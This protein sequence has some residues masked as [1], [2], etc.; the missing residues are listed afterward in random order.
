MLDNLNVG[1]NINNVQQ[2]KLVVQNMFYRYLLVIRSNICII[3]L[4][5]KYQ[6]IK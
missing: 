3:Y 4:S 5:F 1:T 6:D 2:S